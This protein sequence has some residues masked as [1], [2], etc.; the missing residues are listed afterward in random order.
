MQL[1]TQRQAHIRVNED[2]PLLL[3]LLL[4]RTNTKKL[5]K[6]ARAC[7]MRMQGGKPSDRG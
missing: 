6:L 7:V 2:S 5:A 1:H 4:E 3:V